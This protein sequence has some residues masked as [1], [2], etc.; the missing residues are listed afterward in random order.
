MFQSIDLFH[1]CFYRFLLLSQSNSFTRRRTQALNLRGASSEDL[2]D[3]RDRQQTTKTYADTKKNKVS[4]QFV[5][6]PS[7]ASSHK[8]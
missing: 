5:E 1:F 4:S 6:V 7:Q 2:V 3:P 8:S